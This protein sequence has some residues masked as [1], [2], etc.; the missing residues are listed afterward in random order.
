MKSH[1]HIRHCS[2]IIT[3]AM[4]SQIMV[5]CLLNRLFRRRSKKTSKPHVAGL[6][7]ENS[8]VNSPHKRPVMRKM[9]MFPF[10][11]VIMSEAKADVWPDIV[12]SIVCW[13]IWNKNI[14]IYIKLVDKLKCLCAAQP[15]LK[16]LWYDH[17]KTQSC[18]VQ[19]RLHKICYCLMDRTPE[20]W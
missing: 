9:K 14:Y 13:V 4:A 10:D 1:Q 17:F 12:S 2:D 18:I 5:S 7:E 3:S 15:S 16:F 11:D 20:L 19:S 6:Y 8:P